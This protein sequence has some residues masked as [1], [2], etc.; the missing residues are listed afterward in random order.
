MSLAIQLILAATGPRSRAR[1]T[2]QCRTPMAAQER[3]L[4]HIL[5]KNRDTVFGKRYAFS[6]IVSV[7]EF[8]KRVPLHTYEDLRPYVEAQM[9][10]EPRMLTREEPIFFA[11]TSGTT[12]ASKFIPVTPES[13]AAKSQLVRLLLYS[14]YTSRPGILSGKILMVVSPEVERYAPC[15]TA[16]GAESGHMYRNMPKAMNALYSCPY[17]VCLI[18][19]YTARYFTW[20]RIA[21][22]QSIS[23][24]FACNPST[25]ILLGERLGDHTEAIIR[26][27]R[28]GTLN[29]HGEIRQDLKR[30]LE[31]GLSPDPER[32]AQLERAADGNGGRLVPKEIWPDLAAIAC[33]KG[34]TVGMYLQRFDR[35]LPAGI[36]VHDIGYLSSEHRGSVPLSEEGDGS[37]LAVPTNVY[38][39]LPA[40]EDTP[41]K[42]L[43]LLTVD[44]VEVGRRYFVY[45]TTLG[46]LYRYDMNDIIEV[47]GTYERTPVIR[48]VQKGKGVVSFTGEKLTESHVLAAVEKTLQPLRGEYDFIAAVGEMAGS[49]P[50]YVFLIEFD[51]PPSDREGHALV[52]RLDQELRSQNA[53]Y[54]TKRDSQRLSPPVIRAVRRG[55]FEEYRKRMITRGRHD[56][57]FKILRITPDASFAS[58]FEAEGEFVVDAGA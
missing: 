57:Q 26:D 16:C 8:K 17:E 56:G 27:V 45:V 48:F 40:E 41:P 7:G 25:V 34:G 38:E 12:G 54:A 49:R 50:R 58:E 21:A 35:Y 24:I 9:R 11:T 1:F 53:E 3:L 32:A 46:G 55:Q 28:D 37:V 23:L 6:D 39:F 4:Q 19:D 51:K 44:E 18:K 10:G 33:W 15:G 30:I 31:A 42:P 52:A 13:R 22:G 20:L 47:V 14:L 29:P 43:D 36:A 2:E 5:S